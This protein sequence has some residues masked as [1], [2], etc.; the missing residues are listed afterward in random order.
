MVGPPLAAVLASQF[1]DWKLLYVAFGVVSVL[2][3][4]LV[5]G[6]DVGF[7]SNSGQFLMKQFGIAPDTATMVRSVNFFGRLPGTLTGA[8]ILTSISSHKLFI[9]TSVPGIIT[10]GVSVYTLKK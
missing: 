6:I 7:N 5:V 8:V 9:W 1:G 10:F 2:S 3:I 4:F